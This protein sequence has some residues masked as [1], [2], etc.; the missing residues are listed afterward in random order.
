MP[1]MP[2]IFDGEANAQYFTS[3]D[4]GEAFWQ[5]PLSEESKACAAFITYGGIYE[6]QTMLF[7]LSGAPATFQDLIMRVLRGISGKYALCYFADVIIFSSTFEEHL[8]H[9]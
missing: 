9:I 6:F 1:L 5:V 4:L 2:D 7:G 3:L 8:Q